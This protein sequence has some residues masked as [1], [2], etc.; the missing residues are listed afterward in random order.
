MY[1]IIDIETTGLNPHQEKITEIAILIHDGKQICDEFITLVNPEK[2]IPYRITQL[3]G[4][5]TRMLEGAPRFYEIARTIVELT[6]GHTLVGHNVSFDYNFLKAEFASFGYSFERETLCTC[7][8]SRKLIPYQ[9]SYSLGKLCQAMNIEN[10]SRHRAAGDA[11]ATAKLFDLLR[12]IKPDLESLPKKNTASAGINKILHEIPHATGVYYLLNSSQEVIYVGKSNNIHDR[13]LQHFNNNSTRKGM[14]MQSNIAAVNWEITGSELIA[15]LLESEEI[16]RL[17]PLYNKSQRRSFFNYGLFDY[18]NSEGYLCLKTDKNTKDLVP[19]TSYTSMKEAK[20]HLAEFARTHE[21]CFKLSGLYPTKGACFH[22][23][24]KECRGACIGMEPT[25]IYNERVQKALETYEFKHKNFY[26]FDKGRTPNER[27]VL[28]V[29]N[30]KYLG[31]G[32]IDN[33]SDNNS[34]NDLDH[35]IKRYNDNRDVQS[36]LKSYMR[37]HS[38]MNILPFSSERF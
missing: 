26:L 31:F 23:H 24:I 19:I 20:E 33:H 10:S 28:K 34:L 32:F 22:Y 30:G 2:I 12:T 18:I 15:L 13:I 16:K 17:L 6:K 14:E 1:A 27:S 8:L 4:I 35:H 29:E 11:H 25:E 21:L 3:T 5:N 37:R 38:N 36:L 9:P 7:R